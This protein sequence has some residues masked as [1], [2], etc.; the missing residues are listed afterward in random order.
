[1]VRTFTASLA[2]ACM[3]LAAPVATR[4]QA[5]VSDGTIRDAVEHRLEIDPEVPSDVITVRSEDGI[6][7]LAGATHEL[8]SKQRAARIAETVRGVRAVVNTIEVEPIA[9]PSDA[10]LREEIEEALR[11]DAATS[12]CPI[13]ATAANGRV[14]L[15][16]EVGSWAEKDL[17]ENL[18]GGVAGVTDLVDRIVVR[19]PATRADSDI[20]EDVSQ[21][22]RWDVRAAGRHVA[23]AVD[24]GAVTLTGLVGSAAEKRQVESDAWVVGVRSVDASGVGVDARAADDH[25]RAVPPSVTSDAIRKAVERALYYDPRVFSRTVEVGVSD[26]RT[27]TLHGD[28]ANLAAA[29]AATRDARNT[30]GVRFVDDGLEVRAAADAPVDTAIYRMVTRSLHRDPGLDTSRLQVVVRDGAVRLEGTVETSLD[31]AQVDEIVSRVGGVRRVE[32]DLIVSK[33]I[34]PLAFEP[35]VDQLRSDDGG[36]YYPNVVPG[37]FSDSQVEREIERR[38]FW[39]RFVDGSEISVRV[40]DG[41]A[42]LTGAVDSSSAKTHATESAYGGGASL[43]DNELTVRG[44]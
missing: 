21:R 18:A 40:H 35:Y 42:T 25:L 26:D 2:I 24:I 30:T 20:E 34:S 31:R 32:N 15:I 14:T 8:L 12:A 19:P 28:V 11:S 36:W 16:G 17:A 39:S 22:L 38:F 4:A 7:T 41:V 13:D 33:P 3:M 27:V 9:A 37:R 1:M 23:A 10:D 44:Q 29:R 6:V 5:S 43:V